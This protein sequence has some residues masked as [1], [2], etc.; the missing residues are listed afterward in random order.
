VYVHVISTR[1][2][3]LYS[4]QVVIV[5]RS[6]KGSHLAGTLW[7][8]SDL[9]ASTEGLLEHI[10][11]RW[12]IEVLFADG[13]EEFGLDQYQLMSATALVRFWSLA[14]L[15]Y[16][17]LDEERVRLQQQWQRPVTIG[18]TRREIQRLHR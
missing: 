18:E 6:L 9:E 15:A 16:A 11:A 8:S 7:A 2:R 13:K 4:C 14:L 1:V 10:S 5:C 17:F 12:D 3:K